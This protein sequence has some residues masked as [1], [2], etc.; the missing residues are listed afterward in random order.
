M[1]H[2][3]T[4]G[5]QK[6]RC[7]TG[8]RIMETSDKKVGK[9]FLVFAGLCVIALPLV[10]ISAFSFQPGEETAAGIKAKLSSSTMTRCRGNIWQACLLR[11]PLTIT[12]L[13]DS[14]PAL[15]PISPIKLT[16][17]IWPGWNAW[18]AMPRAVGRKSSNGTHPLLPIRNRRPAANAILP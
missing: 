3:Q 2:I 11:E 1:S 7:Q 10:V 12:M 14:I 9:I 15:R 17:R 8:D 13:A 5:L 6:V 18:P 4:A 16:N